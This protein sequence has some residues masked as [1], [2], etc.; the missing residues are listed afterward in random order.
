EGAQLDPH[1]A[2]IRRS[3]GRTLHRLGRRPEAIAEYRAALELEPSSVETH[4]DLGVL[5]AESGRFIEAVQQFEEAL[6]LDPSD[7]AA[8]DNLAR[9]R[10]L[11]APR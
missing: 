9:S 1:R 10:A 6:R 11:L 7:P 5:F 4:N 8:R 2:I 3:L